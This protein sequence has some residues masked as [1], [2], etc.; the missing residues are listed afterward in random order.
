MFSDRDNLN[1]SSSERSSPKDQ[2]LERDGSANT[3]DE[4]QNRTPSISLP[5]GGGAIRGIGEKFAANP[6]TGTG[7]M[8]VPIAISP[9][10]SGFD[11]PQ[12]TLS[13]DSGAGNGPFGFGWSLS[14]PAITRKTDKGLPQYS[15]ADESDVFIL[16]GS[17]D[18]VP[19]LEANG[20]RFKDDTTVPGFI[21]H[22][23][24]PRIEGL[25]ARI[26]R[27]TDQ[28]NGEVHWR[29]ITRDNITTMYGK[30]PESRVFVPGDERLVFSW[31][32]CES[33]DDKGNAIVYKYEAEDSQGVDLS[34]AHEQNRTGLAR[35]AKRYLKRIKYGNRVSRLI[36]PDLSAAEWLFELVFDYNEGHYEVLPLDPAL[37]EAEQHSFVRAAALLRPGHTWTVRPD[38]FSVHRAGFEVRTYRRCHRVLMFH[39][40][41]ELGP[42]PYLVRSTEFEYADFDYTHPT[43]IE[44]ELAHPGSTRFASFIRSVSQSGY[45]RDDSRPVLERNDARYVTYLKKSLPPVEF[46]YT[47]AIIQEDVEDIES[48]SIDNLPIG[49]DGTNY[50]WADLDGEGLSGLLTQQGNAWFYKRN[51][52]PL[53]RSANDANTQSLALFAPLELLQKMPVPANLSGG[54]QLMDLAADGQ[55]DV[56]DF[57]TPTPGFTERTPDEDWERFR[58]FTSLPNIHWGDPN[59]RFVDLTGDGLSDILI[60]EDDAFTWHSSLGEDGFAP[61]EKVSQALNEEK[62]PRLVFADGTQSIHLADMSGDGLTDIVRIRNG[63][64]SY[65]PNLGYGRFGAKVA[66]DGAP[67]FDAPDRFDHR[68]LHLADIDGSGV[69]DIIYLRADGV[70]LYFNQSGNGWSDARA[71]RVFPRVDD[72]STVSV[73]D[74]LGNGTACL[75]WSSPLPGDAGRQMRYV[76]LMKEKPHL[77]IGMVNNCGAETRVRYAPSTRFYLYDKAA[78]KPWITKLPF[79]VHVVEQVETYDYISRNHFTSRYAYHHGY[80][81]GVEREFRGFGMVEQWDTQALAGLTADGGFPLGD[82][83][84]DASHVPPVHTKTWFH[85]GVYLGADRVS[86]FFAGSL[87]AHD[88][89]EYYREPAWRDDDVEAGKRLLADTVLPAGLTVTE[90]RDA[91]RALK[92]SMLRQEVYADDGTVKAEHPYTVVE[93]NFTVVRVQPQHENRNAIFFTHSREVLNYHYERNPTDPRINH[94]LTLSVDEYGNVLR[95]VSIGYRRADVLARQPEQT[96]TH[97][98][99]TLNRVVNRDD[100]I[101]WRHIGVP[102]ETRTYEVVKPPEALPRFAWEEIR[103][104]VN[105]LVP[106]DQIEP[107]ASQTIPY[108]QWDWRKRWNPLT[109]PGGLVNS[110][111]RLLEHIRTLY[112]PDDLGVAQNNVLE[113]LPLATVESLA[114]PGESYKLAF[115]T[116]LL[117]KIYQ[118]P[119][120]VIAPPG[121]PLPESLLPTPANVLNEG[122][123][124][125]G[126]YVDLNSNGNYWIPSGR[127]FFSPGADDAAAVE[128]AHARRH[129]FLTHRLRDPFHTPAT[130]TENSVTYDAHDLLVLRTR[131]AIG[132][133]ITA[134]ERDAAGN[135][136]PSN[137][138]RVLKPKLVMDPNRNRAAVVFDALGMVVGTAIMAKPAPAPVEGDSFDSFEPDLTEAVIRDQLVNPLVAPGAILQHATTRLVYDLFAYQRTKNS[139]NPQPAVVYTLE[140]ET[141]DSDP[142]P[143]GGL[144]IRHSFSYSDGFGREIQKKI[145]AEAGPVPQ[146]DADGKIVLGLNRQPEMTP[147]DFSPRWVGS[148][149]TIFNNKG[150]PVRQYESFFTDM[151]RFEFDVRIGVS[152]ILCYDPV[153]RVVATLH[154]NHTWEKVIFDPWRQET[155]DVNDTILLA[156]QS[157]ENVKGFFVHLDGTPRLA[158]VDYLPTWHA[159]RTDPAHAAEASARW[160]DATIRNAQKAAA[161]KATVH[162]GTPTLAHFDSLG[163]SFLV[164]AHNKFKHSNDPPASP[165]TE[166]FQRT[167]TSLDLEGNQHEI[168]DAKDRVVMRYEYDMLSNRVYQ[169]SMEAGERWMLN[170]A[171]GK[172]IR[173][174]DSRAHAFRTEYDPLRRPVRSFATGVDPANPSLELL[175]E[176]QVYGEQHPEDELRNLR[177]VL[178]MQLDQ[179]GV[180]TQEAHDFKGKLLRATRRLAREYKQALSWSV[181]DT[182]VPA[183]STAKLNLATLEASLA[184]LLEVETYTSNTRYDA[185]NRPVQIIAPRSNQPGAKRNVTQPRYNEANLLER[186]DVW[187]DHPTEPTGLLDPALVPPSPVGFNNINYDAKG[188]RL[189]IEYKNGATTHY[190][191]EPET[192]RL[193]HLYTRRGATFTEDCGGEPPPPRFAATDPPPPPGTPC[194]LQNI[195]YTYD[196]VGNLTHIR[197]DA[198]QTIYFKNKLVEPSAEYIY[199]SV[200]RLI[201]AT[202]REHLG[203]VGAAPRPG[204]Y[205]DKPRVGI[206]LS[207]SDGDAVGRYLQRYTYDAVGNF[208][209]MAHRGTDPA[210]PGW[211]RSYSYNEDSQLEPTPKSNRLTSTT[212]GA[213]TETY[214]S[215]GNGYDAHGNMLRMPQLANMQWDFKNQLQRTQRQAVNAE[216]EDGTAHVGERT[217]YAYDASGQRTRKVTE[218]VTD[219][220]R[221]ERIYL[222]GFEIYRRRGVS[223]LVRETLHVMDDKRRIA[224]VETRTEGTEPGLPAQI[225]RCQLSNH[226][227]SASL[228]LDHQAQIISYEEYY[229]F[230]NTSFQAVRNQTETPKRYR[231]T[232]KER[233]EESGL[234]YH[235]ARYYIAWLGR[236]L[237]ADPSGFTD[238]PNLYEYG[239]NNPLVYRDPNGREVEGYYIAPGRPGN[240]PFSFFLGMAAHRLIAYHYSYNHPGSR[241]YYNFDTIAAILADS[242]A[243]DPA[244]LQSAERGLKPDITDV[245][246]REVFEIKPTND[247]S[248]RQGRRQAASYL[249][250]LNRAAPANA[251]FRLG[252]GNS[253]ELGIRFAGGVAGWRL[254]WNTTEPGVIQYRWQRL[255][256]RRQT[257]EGFREAYEQGLWIDISEAE[258]AQYGEQLYNA[259]EARMSH[260]QTIG[261]A[262]TI[263]GIAVAIV[264]IIAS[265]FIG[266]ARSRTQPGA[267]PGTTIPPVP[268]VRPPIGVP[269]PMVPPPPPPMPP[270]MWIPPM[271]PPPMQAPPPM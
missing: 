264:G 228:E 235:G 26:E 7:S 148:G 124:D 31:L 267:Q 211:T 197:D 90:E 147:G 75:V 40:F 41:D 209:E 190:N 64:V 208:T 169:A 109:E 257:E 60:T 122:G 25:F 104:L 216:D 154:P 258:A 99:L 146:R 165:P 62:G 42:E 46:T 191:Y 4:Q 65:W 28:T 118:R 145:Q 144:K 29:S 210:N 248:L 107:A 72:L 268:P 158:L 234:Y 175:T 204:S 100:Q 83:I 87:D 253:G 120:H 79:L 163:R 219:Q 2:T 141:H 245:T 111:L 137:D 188:Q 50:R 15:D 1:A 184:P 142:V 30:T 198:Q 164:V 202:G 85:T 84:N 259:V 44:A 182:T 255:N 123:A 270:P 180:A 78:G 37:P 108:E 232:G 262:Q 130:S 129:F 54:Q 112:R 256:P 176:R 27:W 97:L 32:I 17:E 221:E 76:Q 22:R 246:T 70:Q 203:Q 237:S 138:Y 265:A 125:R 106:S 224:L 153:Q 167:R 47:Q 226:L 229:P 103:D 225:I 212:I 201:E 69:I 173:T 11:P 105:T 96:E 68:R 38:P 82:N 196:P 98:T 101:D 223:P 186:L 127:I 34:A 128:L 195:R 49:L 20:R 207:A 271:R 249:A 14:L 152:P 239:R 36:E 220:I 67:W 113:L 71:L 213:A 189:S 132:N 161:D 5:K 9:G 86:K 156:P 244:L 269:P 39:R 174:W 193:I 116:A 261:R 178:F 74:L 150:K 80:F 181:V 199:D 171:T 59:L 263:T 24:R 242:G 200:Y 23:Y 240:Q 18:L 92:G 238:S 81:D 134:G 214:S 205:N 77:L 231:Y 56:V 247:E 266:G 222:D 143:A 117:A 241:A 88:R 206:L 149:W 61:A 13:Y 233:D 53:T 251:Q 162:A 185:L 89:G 218:L 236:W 115:R 177:G 260:V 12:P 58:P 102:V 157:D 131:D 170:D 114:V 254:T 19:V 94:T 250:A 183:A 91:Y 95:S 140:R 160:P 192:L 73:V 159:L 252:T 51:L 172:P 57:A 215:G 139:A 243:G 66:M 126:G 155:W 135:L 3:T 230:G 43:T 110:R 48:E 8:T 194:G 136:T 52:S 133:E 187:L 93:Q 33:Y 227:G 151:S 179:A 21:I 10:R 217:W 45:V 166:E 119:L 168:V 6:V 63:D 121:S 35:S 16:S 55:I